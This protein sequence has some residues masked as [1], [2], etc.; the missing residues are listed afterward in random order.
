MLVIRNFASRELHLPDN[1]SYRR[2]ADI[3]RRFVLWNVFA[4]PEFSLEPIESCFPIAGCVAYR[5]YYKEAD[6]QARAREL[7]SRGYDVYVLGVPA[8]S[9]LGW[10]DD[11]V[12]STFVYYPD[13]ELAR[14]LFHELAHQVAYAKGDTVFNESFAVSV[15][16]EGVRRWLAANGTKEQRAAFAQ[17]QERRRQFL[18]LISAC[19]EKL[20]ALYEKPVAEGEKRA[21]KARIFASMLDGYHA[22]RD[23]WGGF[24]GYD[25]FF[26]QEANNALLVSVI[27][28]TDRVPAFRALLAKDRGD[29]QAF[30]ADVKQLVRL[31][32]SE[33]EQKL[34]ALAAR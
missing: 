17:S 31:S 9:T 16:E 6:A 29:L 15:E 33:R 8:Y 32:K 20:S 14:L 24:A 30:Y 3:G 2:Y 10:F 27:A 22:L 11:P 21:E 28:Y 5:G 26:P 7:R 12:L 23:S 1:G 19:R 34:A 25:R 18:A 13:A 4:A